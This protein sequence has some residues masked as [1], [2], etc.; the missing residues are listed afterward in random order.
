MRDVSPTARSIG[1]VEAVTVGAWV[2]VTIGTVEVAVIVGRPGATMTGGLLG[3]VIFAV[4]GIS[5]LA[6]SCAGLGVL[7]RTPMSVA[8]D[9]VVRR[10]STMTGRGVHLAILVGLLLLGVLAGVIDGLVYR[11]LYPTPHLLLGLAELGAVGLAGGLV[12]RGAAR[13]WSLRQRRALVVGALSWVSMGLLS[14]VVVGSWQGLRATMVREGSWISRVAAVIPGET[15]L[16]GRAQPLARND[17]AARCVWPQP[18]PVRSS[19]VP[20]RLD[21]LLITVDAVRG[22]LGGPKIKDTFP[23]TMRRLPHAVVFDRAYAPA[24]RTVYSSY[25]MLTGMYPTHL[26]FVAA[27]TD[28]NDQIHV[29]ADDHPI[30]VDPNQWRLRH[31]YPVHD[32]NPTLASLLNAEGYETSAIIPDV[33]LI[34]ASGITREF[35]NVDQ[36]PYLRNGRRDAVGIT[37]GYST[38]AGVD[39]FQ[40]N[41]SDGKIG[42]AARDLVPQFAWIHYLDPHHPYEPDPPAT[43]QSPAPVRY[44]SE[45][46]RVDREIARLLD[47]IAASRGLDNTL[48]IVTGDHGEEFRDHGGLQ[49]GT[50]LYEELMRVPLVIAP[51]ASTTPSDAGHH[52]D[53]PVSL[54]DLVPTILDLLGVSSTVSFDGRS[55]APA[56]GGTD[57]VL[58]ARPVFLYNTS[59][60]ES[61]DRT[62][63]VVDGDHKLIVREKEQTAELY[64]LGSDPREQANLVDTRA[65]MAA[66]LRCLLRAALLDG[67]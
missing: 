54:V 29:L 60:T 64:D 1:L 34:P 17:S 15:L 62:V 16:D 46:H 56:L 3:A 48:I 27:T 19:N 39:V 33:S 50:T 14:L 35:S 2:G 5:L 7:L 25:A 61:F 37:S 22:D 65:E 36:R 52:V 30:M 6:V 59:Y 42:H 41:L 55:L 28:V 43:M 67:G 45:I 13:R 40:R 4:A 26:D 21:V 8:H 18:A 63:A 44:L 24:P 20:R 47:A 9:A 49:H 11:N 57:A 38:D 12:A 66:S 51:P 32:T 31:R 53:T 10:V 23:E 58:G